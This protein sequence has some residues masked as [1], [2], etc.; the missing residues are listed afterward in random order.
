MNE[1]KIPGMSLCNGILMTKL[2]EVVFFIYKLD[3]NTYKIQYIMQKFN[4]FLHIDI[5]I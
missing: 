1:I 4:R 5:Q 3:Q 2:T